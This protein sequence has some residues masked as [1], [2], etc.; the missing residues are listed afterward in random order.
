MGCSVR[1]WRSDCY[2]FIGPRPGI[3]HGHFSVNNVPNLVFCTLVYFAADPNKQT[4]RE[5]F[6][7]TPGGAEVLTKPQT[8]SISSAT[9]VV[10]LLRAGGFSGWVRCRYSGVAYV[11]HVTCGC[12]KIL[13]VL[14][15]CH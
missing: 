2:R 9:P 10:L 14:F 1:P 11:R 6:R 7:R 8:V 12:F 15:T 4:N 5:S 13:Y 3:S